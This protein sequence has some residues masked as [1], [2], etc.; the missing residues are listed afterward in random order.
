MEVEDISCQR[1][2][3]RG[4]KNLQS[5]MIERRDVMPNFFRRATSMFPAAKAAQLFQAVTGKVPDESTVQ[6]FQEQAAI[7]IYRNY[8]E[9]AMRP[10]LSELSGGYIG[11][12]GIVMDPPP[13][14]I[15]ERIIQ[16]LNEC[17][18]SEK[19]SPMFHGDVKKGISEYKDFVKTYGKDATQKERN[20]KDLEIRIE[21]GEDDDIY[22]ILQDLGCVIAETFNEDMEEVYLVQF[23]DG[24]KKKSKDLL[25]LGEHMLQI[26]K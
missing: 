25:K 17:I 24:S 3:R 1:D 5:W 21:A 11:R 12:N 14:R 13:S 18:Y 7:G 6:W 2:L 22:W 16:H 26:L 10:L 23:P 8:F 4:Q 9:L 19:Y 15:A 20:I